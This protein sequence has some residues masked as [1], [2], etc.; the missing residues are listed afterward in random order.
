M[1]WS[2]QEYYKVD[3]LP[4]ILLFSNINVLRFQKH[5][6]VMSIVKIASSVKNLN[7][8]VAYFCPESSHMC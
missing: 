1:P 7:F 2:S 4:I 3:K 6:M 5:I 8:I